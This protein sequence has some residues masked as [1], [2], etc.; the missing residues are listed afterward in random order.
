MRR[1]GKSSLINRTTAILSNNE[2][3]SIVLVT[4]IAVII[5]AG[6]II[7]S[8]NSSTL[9]A[10]ADKQYSKDQAYEAATSLGMTIDE[11]I[12]RGSLNLS[13]L[14]KDSQAENVV[15]TDSFKNID[16]TAS[17][18]CISTDTY[19]VSVK[20]LSHGSEYVFSA[21]YTGSGTA[22]MRVA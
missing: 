19:V 6:V 2:G 15:F 17:V 5:I 1:I 11:Y 4:I 8:I 3:A 7:L 22:Y 14:V 20:A 9:L 21:T 12:S 16:V 10:F 13:D 18:S